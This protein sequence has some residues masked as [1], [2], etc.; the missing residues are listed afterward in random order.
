MAKR[1][2]RWSKIIEEAGIQVRLYTREG[3]DA[4]YREV[5]IN[6]RREQKS[7]K[8]SDRER[9]E[10]QA[11]ALARKLAEAKLTGLPV[12]S[13]TLG[14]V[15]AA[16]NVHRLPSLSEDR[17]K[18]AKSRQA[19]FLEAW[20]RDLK[21]E[22]LSQ[23]HV[24]KYSD[25]RRTGRLVSDTRRE[26]L[27]D[28][29]RDGA[30]DGDF[31][32]LSAMFNWAT[33]FKTGGKRFLV[34]NPLRDVTWPREKNVRRPVASHERY[35]ATLAKCDEVDPKGRL[36]LALTLARYTGRR[37]SAI[38]GLR[39]SD[40]LLERAHVQRTLA[41]MGQD[42][43]AAD[44][45]PHGGIRW[46]A[47]N[48]KQGF[49]V[50]TPISKVVREALEAYLEDNPMVGEAHVF[51]GP[52]AGKKPPRKDAASNGPLR[53]D[54]ASKWLKRA[55]ELAE[56]PKLEQG[57]W[58]PYR[59]L[60]ASERKHLPDVDVAAAGGWRDTRALKLSYQHAD[61][62]TVLQVVENG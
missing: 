56:L 23:A 15:F 12:E 9:A 49:D 59:R 45:F 20:G 44:H 21:L 4:I 29:V 62:A 52:R 19:L 32:M 46:R 58:H 51:P 35:V 10:D 5:R 6:G 43:R 8:H 31:R 61:P 13:P 7:L 28:G 37:E 47:E 11:K 34:E 41:A 50:L 36:A 17:A 25:A 30:I 1:K 60:W 16:Y 26:D 53:R 57:R 48:D 3:T 42:E 27:K 38:L 2:K 33:R 55:E 22:D 39:R 18:Y 24:D 14:Q 54:T 40:V